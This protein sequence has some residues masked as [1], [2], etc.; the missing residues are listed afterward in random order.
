MASKNP[1]ATI[2][3]LSNCDVRHRSEESQEDYFTITP[4][5]PNDFTRPRRRSKFTELD[6]DGNSICVK[7]NN[8]TPSIRTDLVTRCRSTSLLTESSCD[9]DDESF[10]TALPRFSLYPRLY[11]LTLVLLIAVPLLYDTRWLALPAASILGAR[12]GLIRTADRK[13]EATAGH[14]LLQRENTNTDV[15]SRWSAQSA[16]VN[17]TMYLYGGHATQQPGEHDG[18]WTNDFFTVD[19]TKS[20]DIS[21]PV[22]SGL[23][24]PSGPPAVANGFLWNSYDSLY[25]YGGIVSDSP[26]AVPD[27]Y[28]LWEYQIK[29]AKWVEHQNPKT[30]N[31]NSS[32]GGNQ[33]VLQTGEGAGISI[34]ELG[35]GYFFAGHLDHYTTP[36]WSIQVARLY[37]KSLLEFTFPGYSNDGVEDLSGGKTA[38]SDGAWR[39]VTEGGIQD[40]AK[41]PSRADG[42]LVFVPGFGADGILLSI[43]GGLV[44]GPGQNESS[45]VSSLGRDRLA[46]D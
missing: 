16:L 32:D 34:P 25:L 31:G 15:C 14:E 44:T 11:I 45:F 22:V 3:D 19:L 4:Q 41:F 36:A 18:T 46:M 39:N 5:S 10:R 24:Q 13:S 9:S 37:L 27:P 29:N 35:R 2:E 7:E 33:P 17:G 21:A 38:G 40:T 26:A 6:V 30:S 42:A 23:P 43:G 20:W 1:V 28:S 12:A 8:L